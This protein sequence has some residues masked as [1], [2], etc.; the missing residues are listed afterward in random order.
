LK[1]EGVPGEATATGNRDEIVIDSF[2]MASRARRP[3][4][5]DKQRRGR[6]LPISLLLTNSIKPRPCSC[7]GAHK[8]PTSQRR[9]SPVELLA[10]PQSRSTE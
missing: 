6:S 10:L 2:S 3:R 1:L 7:S 9:S 5:E 4:E 8:A